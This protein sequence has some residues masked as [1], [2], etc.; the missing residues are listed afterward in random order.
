VVELRGNQRGCANNNAI[1]NDP[2]AFHGYLLNRVAA[3]MRRT[4]GSSLIH[5]QRIVEAGRI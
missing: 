3:S 2:E 5:E 4:R 1:H